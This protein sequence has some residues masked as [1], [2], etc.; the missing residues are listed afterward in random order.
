MEKHNLM[1]FFG[2]GDPVVAPGR[3]EVE[4]GLVVGIVE[5][6]LGPPTRTNGLVVGERQSG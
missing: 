4:V 2:T 6:G 5:A 1:C 3:E